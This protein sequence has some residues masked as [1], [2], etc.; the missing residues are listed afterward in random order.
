MKLPELPVK[1]RALL[2]FVVVDDTVSNVRKPVCPVR[3]KLSASK[4]K[5]PAPVVE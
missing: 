4:V 3:E 5:G 2:M 1:K